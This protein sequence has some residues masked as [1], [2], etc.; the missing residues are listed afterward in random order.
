MWENFKWLLRHVM[1][2]DEIIDAGIDLGRT[3]R[4]WFYRMERAIATMFESR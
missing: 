4:S 2:G 1:A 3:D